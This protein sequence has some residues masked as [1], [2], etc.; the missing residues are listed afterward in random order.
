MRI[1]Q[2]R[3][4]ALACGSAVLVVAGLVAPVTGASAAG[5]GSRGVGDSYFPL[6]GNGGVD[7]THYDV[8]VRYGFSSR[9]LTGRAVITLVP[10][11]NLRRFNLDLLLTATEVSVGGRP[12]RHRKAGKHELV[13]TPAKQLRAGVPAKVVVRYAGRPGDV[14]YLGEKSWAADGHEVAAVNQPHMAP[15]WF[16]ANDHPSDKATF[17]VAVTVPRGKQVISNGE[18]VRKDRRAKTATWHWRARDPMATYLAY[19]VAGDFTIDRGVRGGRPWLTAVSQRL[20]RSEQRIA[21][22]QVRRTAALVARLEEDL[23]PYPFETTGGVVTSLDLGFALENQTRPVYPGLTADEE[24]LL[25]HELAHQWFGDSLTLRRWR[26]IWLNEGAAT[27]MEMRHGEQ[28]RGVDPA[29]WLEGQWRSYGPGSHMWRVRI[30]DPGASL[31]FS[32]AVYVRGGMTMQALRN[33]IG[34]QEF[35]TLLR[36]WLDE[37]RN[38]TVTGRAF[39][40]LAAQIS[41][42]DL[43]PFFDAWLR[44]PRRPARTVDNGLLA[45]APSDD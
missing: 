14:S 3:R 41:G 15:F 36:T 44:T 24:W 26:D 45:S 43:G 38:Q 1:G 21:R 2:A 30:G 28:T 18:L 9:R 5:N 27:F 11:V 20:G 17:R 32:D 31:L 8:R 12:A 22:Q 7:V 35:W 40:R 29:R 4:L 42:E 25:V 16:P 34:E 19:F 10:K 33:R 13:I 23:G 6:D 37:H 39:E